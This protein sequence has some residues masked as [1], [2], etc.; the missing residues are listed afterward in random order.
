MKELLVLFSTLVF[1]IGCGDLKEDIKIPPV[2]NNIINEKTIVKDYDLMKKSLSTDQDS[3]MRLMVSL[4][5]G[6]EE[7]VK[8][9]NVSE[10]D[11]RGMSSGKRLINYVNK[12]FVEFKKYK[13]TYMNLFDELDSIVVEK[14]KLYESINKIYAEIDQKNLQYQR[15]IDSLQNALELK[16]G[17]LPLNHLFV[18]SWD[19]SIGKGD[20][21]NG[22]FK[23]VACKIQNNDDRLFYMGYDLILK[24]ADSNII[25]TL[26]NFHTYFDERSNNVG[27][28]MKRYY[29]KENNDIYRKLKNVFFGPQTVQSQRRYGNIN[30][31]EVVVRASN[32]H[33]SPKLGIT[34]D[35]MYQTPDKL[36]GWD[37]YELYKYIDAKKL[38]M[39]LANNIIKVYRNYPYMDILR[40]TT[41]K[42]LNG[43]SST[44]DHKVDSYL[45]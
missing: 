33:G 8:N 44:R 35:I 27:S 30:H 12:M 15:R 37:P 10:K 17:K 41:E 29:E 31:Y 32:S 4:T 22:R 21:E 20:N 28:A 7:F 14:S 25:V 39:E 9:S 38:R 3:L 23:Y 2:A 43:R 19:L 42:I 26:P 36:T 16:H 11:S 1:I 24:D 34:D 18:S 6:K 40:N 13:V 5:R 45:P